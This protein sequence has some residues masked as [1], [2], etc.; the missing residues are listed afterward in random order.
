MLGKT[1]SNE[2]CIYGGHRLWHSP[3][4]Q[5]RTYYPDN[6]PVKLEQHGDFVRVIQPTETITGIQKEIDLRLSP[7]EASVQVTHR[8]RNHNLWAVELAPWAL[9]VMATGGTCIIPMPPRGPHPENLIPSSTLT[10]WPYTDMSDPRWTWGY[11]YILLRQDPSIVGKAQ[12]LGA[13]VP[14]GWGAYARNGHLFLKKSTYIPNTSYPD[15]GCSFS[16]FTNHEML[17]LETLGALV[18]LAPTTQLEHVENWF[19]FRDIPTPKSDADVD[20]HILPKIETAR[21]M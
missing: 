11:K 13:S 4:A 19:L 15:L 18:K 14:D 12:K 1:G 6:V 16:I 20:Q 21:I 5:P 9:S 3:E 2:W 17:E 7:T 8:L 10:L